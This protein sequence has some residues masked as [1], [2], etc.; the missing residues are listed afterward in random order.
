MSP[1]KRDGGNKL[2]F[3]LLGIAV[4]I[5]IA[6]LVPAGRVT[7]V[8]ASQRDGDG[9][10]D[11]PGEVFGTGGPDGVQSPGATSGPG[12]GG[13]SG[14]VG[15]GG[16]GKGGGSAISVRGVTANKIKIG[17]GIPDIGVV[18]ALGPNYDV[19]DPREQMEALL[20]GWKDRGLVPVHGRDIEFDYRSYD[21][22]GTQQQRA[23]CEGWATDDKVFAVLAV[24][25]FWAHADC[26]TKEY[27]IPLV[28]ADQYTENTY[29]VSGGR[30][31]TLM[32]STD[33]ILRNEAH[34]AHHRGL[35]TGQRIGLY[36]SGASADVK[37]IKESII[38]ELKKLGYGSQIVIEV[39]ASNVATGA[40]EDSIAADKFCAKDVSL[41]I[42]IA[43]AI[44]QTNFMYE[45]D[46]Q[47]C[48]MEYI[49]NDFLF[50]TNDTAAHTFPPSQADG[51]YGMTSYRFGEISA[52]MGLSAP[53]AA[54][55]ENYRKYS[56]KNVTYK[57]APAEW[58]FLEQGCDGGTVLLEALQRAG[59]NLT[60][61]SLFAALYQ[62]RNEVMGVHANV[63]LSPSKFGG[64]DMQRTVQWHGD[65]RCWIA[66]GKFEPFYVP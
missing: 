6:N 61:A 37:V 20:R 65:C 64:V 32:P 5:L 22:V 11:T 34:W 18:K 57:E 53:G 30:L 43:G 59:R 40:P 60:E 25:N 26:V 16:P 10:V 50:S 15:P 44:N 29:R 36:Y 54:C 35:L 39:T 55:A 51:I 23:A 24:S 3:V 28:T 14:P 21:I 47:N 8:V 7:T 9:S 31:F 63:T 33:K 4:G 49:E 41:A 66:L 12:I 2:Y 42:L 1:V 13:P 46:S 56:G 17:V 27:R 48:H 19:G 62:T 58:L 45:A 52:G 38:A